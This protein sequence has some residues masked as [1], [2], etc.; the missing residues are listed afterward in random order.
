[1]WEAAIKSKVFSLQST[2]RVQQWRHALHLFLESYLKIRSYVSKETEDNEEHQEMDDEKEMWNHLP[3]I[4]EELEE[5][6]K[7][8]KENESCKL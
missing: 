3:V 5:F 2:E 1:M 6:I 4:V 8:L 7:S